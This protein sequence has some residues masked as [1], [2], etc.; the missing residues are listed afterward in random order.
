V[1]IAA[2]STHTLGLRA[3]GTVTATGNNTDGQCEIEGF[4]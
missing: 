2:G 3:D 1:A 4:L